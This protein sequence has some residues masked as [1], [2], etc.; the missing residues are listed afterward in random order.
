MKQI[1]LF[2]LLGMVMN[3]AVA[4]KYSFT[5]KGDI[6]N[7]KDGKV[8]LY[9]PEDSLNVLLATDMK[10]GLFTLSG[11][12]AEPGYYTL[13]VAGVKFPIV[14]DGK[15][16]TLYGNYLEPE[17][18][19]LK[20]SPAVKTRLTLD[21]LYFETFDMLVNEALNKYYQMTENGQK[22]SDKADEFIGKA[23]QDAGKNWRTHFLKFIKEHPDDLYV[24]VRIMKEMGKNIDWGK[25]AY[26]LLTPEIQASQP[27]RLLKRNLEFKI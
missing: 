5:L 20:G 13:V 12:L 14:L 6:I 3:V 11:K 18:K 4:Q 27:G 21:E 24:P 10:D 22:Q 19:L 17:T 2:V 8:E 9:S 25:E 1:I 26:E 16:M 23:I 7:V 15:Q